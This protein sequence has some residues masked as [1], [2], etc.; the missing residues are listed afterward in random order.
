MENEN[1]GASAP[2]EVDLA[3]AA[4]VVVQK[5]M[6]DQRI[7]LIE[8]LKKFTKI[9]AEDDVKTG[10]LKITSHFTDGLPY[11]FLQ[12]VYPEVELI[13]ARK[14]LIDEGK[15]VQIGK[16]GNVIIKLAEAK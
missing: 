16:K 7:G 15:I 5:N 9:G 6:I 1:T 4:Q 11:L 10:V 3:L 8:T 12:T 13:K 2:S 14:E